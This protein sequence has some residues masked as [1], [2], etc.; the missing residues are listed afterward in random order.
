MAVTFTPSRLHVL[1]DKFMVHGPLAFS[2][3]YAT[4][5]DALDLTA[6]FQQE[7]AGVIDY[8]NIPPVDGYVFSYD[9]VN[10]KV[11]GWS[12]ANTELT[13]AAYPAGVTGVSVNIMVIGS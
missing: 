5:G 8:V 10:K 11:Q 9:Y 13:A 7:G 3:T 2:S 1:G 6:L 12:A 4:G